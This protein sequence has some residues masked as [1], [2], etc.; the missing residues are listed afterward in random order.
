MRT[1]VLIYTPTY[2]KSKGLQYRLAMLTKTLQE[3]GYDVILYKDEHENLL[4]TL[5]TY[6]ARCLLQAKSVW[7]YLGNSIGSK[8]L[9]NK[10]YPDIVFLTTDV[11]SGAIKMIKSHGIKVLLLLED[12]SVD[13]LNIRGFARRKILNNLIYFA[14]EADVI[15]T[16][17]ESFS[18]RINEELGLYS[19]PIPPGLE[20]QITEEGAKTRIR[21]HESDKPRI[22]HA[23]QLV[24]K[25]E[26]KLLNTIA[27]K[28]DGFAEIYALKAGRYYNKVKR[29]SNIIWYHYQSVHEAIKY[30]KHCHI[31][32]IATSRNA[33][34]FTSQ[35]FH[36][37]LLQPVITITNNYVDNTS[38]IPLEDFLNNPRRLQDEISSLMAVYNWNIERLIQVIKSKYIRHKAHEPLM[39]IL[40]K[41]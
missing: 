32:L 35:W 40:N 21:A 31:G 3:N 16:P 22:L 29:R 11:C 26:A 23:R 5:Y 27:E 1:R 13:W 25:Q 15:I 7:T 34:T 18:K 17:S 36:F 12:L 19:L 37:S 33:P 8:V 24:T 38:W 28:I 30:L 6:T 10:P 41:L 14:S 2:N 39:K 4:R 20:L 9:K